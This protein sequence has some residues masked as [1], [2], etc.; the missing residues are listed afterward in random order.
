[1]KATNG[2]VKQGGRGPSMNV[3]ERASVVSRGAVALPIAYLAILADPSWS[4]DL[5]PRVVGRIRNRRMSGPGEGPT[6]PTRCV[7]RNRVDAGTE[8]TLWG[9]AASVSPP[10]S[11]NEGKELLLNEVSEVESGSYR[12][13]RAWQRGPGAR[14]ELWNMCSA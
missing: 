1:M 12:V 13:S 8:N 5:H 7:R 14:H 6:A 10:L 4:R 11:A 3:T 9:I 2:N